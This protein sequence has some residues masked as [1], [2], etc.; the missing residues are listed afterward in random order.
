MP[1]GPDGPG[2]STIAR[3]DRRG[4]D[5]GYRIARLTTLPGTPRR[6]RVPVHREAE[7]KLDVPTGEM[8]EVV[9][10][11]VRIEVAGGRSSTASAMRAA[12]VRQALED[13]G[14]T[15]E[16]VELEGEHATLSAEADRKQMLHV[17]RLPFVRKVSAS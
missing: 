12:R 8:S 17:A 7:D 6:I 16:T 5:M 13:V 4:S 9:P 2:A 15:A 1:E 10:L 11:Q 14:G 3:S